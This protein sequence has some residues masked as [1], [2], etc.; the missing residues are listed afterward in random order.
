MKYKINQKKIKMHN[1]EGVECET[2][3][4]ATR[5]HSPRW[6]L[7][8]TFVK[9]GRTRRFAPTTPEYVGFGRGI[10]PRKPLTKGGS[11]DISKML[12]FNPI[13]KRYIAFP[14]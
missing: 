4:F 11:K 13:K 9:P 2:S 1:P 12:I 5:D 6:N 7:N 3:F 10:P 14:N 8:A